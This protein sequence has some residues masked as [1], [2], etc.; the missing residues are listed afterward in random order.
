LATFSS[1]ILAAMMVS[2]PVG[3]SIVKDLR[4][5]SEKKPAGSINTVRYIYNTQGW[6]GFYI[7][8]SPLMLR[9]AIYTWAVFSG[10]GSFQKRFGWNDAQASIAAG[11]IATLFSQ[12][13]DTLATH[14]QNRVPRRSMWDCIKMMYA[15]DSIGRFYRRFYFRW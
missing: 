8:L 10:K 7:G 3:N 11:S 1:G 4:L 15:E 13:I 14:M 9:E 6:R 2:A 12:P 5:K